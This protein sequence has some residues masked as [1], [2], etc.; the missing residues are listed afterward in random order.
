MLYRGAQFFSVGVASSAVGHSLTKWGVE[1]RQAANP[2]L[3]GEE[4]Y[5]PL[6]P[7]L[8]NSVMW[9]GFMAVS[10]NVRYQMMNGIEE[11]GLVSH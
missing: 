5:K 2:K 11:R 4:P 7:V 10:T 1:R 6:A 8:E 9:G 3:E